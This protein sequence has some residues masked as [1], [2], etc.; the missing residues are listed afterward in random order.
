MKKTKSE[1]E[2]E[3]QQL[4]A[5]LNDART[6]LVETMVDLN[7]VVEHSV[8]LAE[9]VI[10]EAPPAWKFWRSVPGSVDAAREY[11]A[12]LEGSGIAFHPDDISDANLT[13][14]ERVE[15]GD[16]ECVCGKCNCPDAK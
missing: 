11:L 13:D 4:E 1:L 14:C 16:D 8:E 15:L 9:T 2:A 3:I 7:D 6:L 10:A 5:A 12:Q